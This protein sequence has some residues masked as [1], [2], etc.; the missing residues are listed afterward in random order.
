MASK[1]QL[2]NIALYINGDQFPYEADSLEWVDGFGDYQI[3]NLVVG[4]NVTEQV[5]SEDIKTKVGEIKFNLPTTISMVKAVRSLKL[6]RNTNEI[7][8]VGTANGETL[9]LVFTQA[10]IINNPSNKAATEGTIDLEWQS[11]PS[12]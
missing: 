9:A 3:R 1:T 8:L 6:A 11:N 7:Q 10:A 12:Q 4:G 5:F 2:N